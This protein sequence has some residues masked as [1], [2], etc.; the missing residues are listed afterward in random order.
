MENSLSLHR[1]RQKKVCGPHCRIMAN[2]SLVCVTKNQERFE[3]ASTH[4]SRDCCERFCS[5][6]VAIAMLCGISVVAVLSQYTASEPERGYLH[7]LPH[8]QEAQFKEQVAHV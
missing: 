1:E 2:M 6:G 4:C 7:D 8:L 3:A 5:S